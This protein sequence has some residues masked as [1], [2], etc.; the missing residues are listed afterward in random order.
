MCGMMRALPWAKGSQS[1]GLKIDARRVVLQTKG[2]IL[3]A[4]P[5]AA[6]EVRQ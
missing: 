1:F 4:E 3:V 2:C 6:E 5:V